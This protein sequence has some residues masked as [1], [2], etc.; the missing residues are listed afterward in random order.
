[1]KFLE[2]NN[3][4]RNYLQYFA[5]KVEQNFKSFLVN[6]RKKFSTISETKSNTVHSLEIHYFTVFATTKP[7]SEPA[8]V[9]SAWIA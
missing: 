1:M 9:A 6:K 7:T 4:L 8:V 2:V 5:K 3:F